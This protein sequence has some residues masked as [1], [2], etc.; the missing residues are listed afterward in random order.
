MFDRLIRTD[1]SLSL[2][3]V[4]LALAIVIWPHG[5]QKVLGW[6]QGGGPA[7]TIEMFNGAWGIPP[8][9]TV[10]VMLAEFVGPVLL[11]AGFLG[12][13][14]ALGIGL[15]MAGAIYF[16]TG[17][18]GFFMNWYGQP[19]GEGFEFH[20]LVFGMVAALLVGGSGRWSVDRM[21]T[22]RRG[23]GEPG[24]APGRATGPETLAAR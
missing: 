24:Y 2:F 6:W 15:V 21:L 22:R 20:L 5:A 19:R 16:V 9:I 18:W 11:L 23:Y 1:D 8:F 3:F 4:R 10:L 12:R 17:R 14:A 7:K 13:F